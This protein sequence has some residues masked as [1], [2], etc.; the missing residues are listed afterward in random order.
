MA[1]GKMD[2]GGEG[3][4]RIAR[5]LGIIG[6]VGYT[7]WIMKLIFINGVGKVAGTP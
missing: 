6:F 1:A 3:R 4:T 2:R 5:V 7:L